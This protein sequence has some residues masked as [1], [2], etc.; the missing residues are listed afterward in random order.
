MKVAYF[1]GKFVPFDEAKIGVMTHAFNYGTGV[2]EGIR[3][4]WNAKKSKTYLMKLPEHYERLQMS[5]DLLK[6]KLPYS[7]DRLI[8][9][10][11]D[12]IKKNGYKEDV[13]IRPIA[14][15]SQERIGLGLTGIEDD[16]TMFLS[17]FGAYLDSKGIRTCISS[18][19]RVN[20]NVYPKG[21]KVTGIY[22]NSSLAKSEAIEKGYDEA[23]MLTADG[24][25]GEGS[26]ENLLIVKNGKLETP[27]LT[28]N[29]LAGITRST[30]I[31]LARDE[32]GIETIEK[33]VHPDELYESDELFFCGTGAEITPIIEVGD[34]KI[35]G[36]KIGPITEKIQKAY[37]GAVKGDNPKYLHWLTVV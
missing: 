23:I 26:G 20:D 18:W 3:G 17:P 5:A 37:F 25:V 28:E 13:Y 21:A 4:Y 33:R 30:V 10:T 12:L 16:F 27:P 6:I 1:R 29:I 36:G 24:Y 31:D 7:V 14:Y 22:I 2:F 8:Q 32:W 15:K 9:I 11:V 35:N 19:N 34:H